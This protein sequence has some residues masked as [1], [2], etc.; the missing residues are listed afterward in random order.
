VVRVTEIKLMDRLLLIGAPG[1]GKTQV[2]RQLAQQEAK[3]LKKNFID[4]TEM[5]TVPDELL[6]NI[7][8]NPESYYLFLRVSSTHIQPDEI[9]ALAIR[10]GF[11][12][13]LPFR[14]L[15][16]FTVPDVYGVLFIDEL[17][18]AMDEQMALLFSIMDEKEFSWGFKLSGNVKVV[19]AGNPA[20]WSRVA[21]TLPEPLRSKI[22]II[23]V[24]PPSID[25]WAEYMDREYPGKW[26]KV[27]YAYLKF[28]QGDFVRKPDSDTE[29]Y[30]CPR[31]WT[32]L[33]LY[34]INVDRARLSPFDEEYIRGT[35]GTGTA[36]K[37]VSFLRENVSE[38][39]FERVRKSPEAFFDF[40]VGKQFLFLY[41]LSTNSPSEIM[42]YSGLLEVLSSRAPDMLIL[43]FKIIDR[44]KR[45]ELLTKNKDKLLRIADYI[46]DA[47]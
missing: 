38:K 17:P 35:V 18:N 26:N 10:N 37:F 34:L 43:F 2:L 33:A 4:L 42:R 7:R 28:S 22:S 3:N 21:N 25:E 14:K 32:R 11:A 45:V 9:S 1:I 31:S 30:P 29:A 27:V 40:N 47:I 39:D 12:D 19:A 6:N 8:S 13:L 20:E 46:K 5:I 41:L 36:T 15:Y 44:N 16:V 24:D 23:N